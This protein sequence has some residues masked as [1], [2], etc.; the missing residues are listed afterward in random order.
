MAWNRNARLFQVKHATVT[1][2]SDFPGDKD[3]HGI[4]SPPL[5]HRGSPICLVPPVVEAAVR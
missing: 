4:K 1:V 3:D 2:F 5:F